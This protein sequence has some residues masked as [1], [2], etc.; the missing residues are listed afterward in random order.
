MCNFIT[1]QHINFEVYYGEFGFGSSRLVALMMVYTM[2]FNPLSQ[3]VSAMHLHYFFVVI[4][5][6]QILISCQVNKFV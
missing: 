6:L 3:Q 4:L 5:I 2:W 1:D